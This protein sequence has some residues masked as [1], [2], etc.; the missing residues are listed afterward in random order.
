MVLVVLLPLD[1]A[2]IKPEMR[3][4]PSSSPF[5]VGCSAQQTHITVN[6]VD[7][8][9]NPSLMANTAS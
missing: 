8:S 3:E 2:R 6:L 4:I 9:G 1:N 5:L 7:T